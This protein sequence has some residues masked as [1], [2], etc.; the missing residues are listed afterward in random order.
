MRNDL[1]TL[2][3]LNKELRQPLI[4]REYEEQYGRIE[5][6]LRVLA[7][8]NVLDQRLEPIKD[9][10]EGLTN[11]NDRALKHLAK[12][13]ARRMH[14]TLIQSFVRNFIMVFFQELVDQG[15]AGQI[16]LRAKGSYELAKTV[17]A[18]DSH[19]PLI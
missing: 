9:L 18:A 12:L 14:Q 13:M 10:L 19:L 17:I 5:P 1:Q 6:E 4:P 15:N 3:E 7:E 16:D 8:L 2:A 11:G